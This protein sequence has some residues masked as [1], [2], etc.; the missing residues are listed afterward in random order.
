MLGFRRREFIEAWRPQTLRLTRRQGLRK[1]SPD[2]ISKA[3]DETSTQ[4]TRIGLTFVSI[5]AFC[6]LSLLMSPDSALLSNIEKIKVP[7]AGPVSP[8]GFMILGPL[9]L[10]VLRVYL[11][12]Y[13]QHSGRLD[14]LAQSVSVVRPPTLVPLANSWIRLFSGLVFYG[15]LPA[16]M[17]CF[18]WKAAVL[19]KSLLFAVV[20]TLGIG[21]IAC[22]EKMLLSWRP[23]GL[24][25]ASVAIIAV[26]MTL[27]FVPPR[28]FN[29]YQANL[30]GLSL[31]RMDLR[32]AD[33]RGA[34]LSGAR[35]GL[36]EL[37]EAKLAHANLSGASL[38]FAKLHRADLGSANLS[39]TALFRAE[40]IDAELPHANLSNA[41]L[42]SA[43][44][45]GARLGIDIPIGNNTV[46]DPE[47]VVIEDL[48]GANLS[49]ARL[50][51]ADLRGA[52]LTQVDLSDANLS[53]VKNLTQAQLDKAC[54]N[55]N[56]KLPKELTLKPCG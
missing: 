6:F 51:F 10:I 18:A 7:L 11:Q 32:W 54:G 52:D 40:L 56:T 1:L 8:Y 29:L 4:V 36:A 24:L 3:R 27:G 13:V 12:I 35:L 45:S 34:N 39:G 17:F 41:N 43:N 22:H 44:L 30:S 9:V 21:V 23:K 47:S 50:G 28:R 15:L 53:D 46:L 26:A 42:E 37:Y 5:A 14:R 38:N 31:T 48:G 20:T 2:L 49:G 55:A 19:P 25:A 33:L 16:M